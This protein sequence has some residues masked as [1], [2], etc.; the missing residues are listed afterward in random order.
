MT[1]AKTRSSVAHVLASLGPRFLP[2]AEAASDDL[3]LSRLL[4][5]SLFQISV[6]M[7]MVMLVGTLNRVMIVELQVPATLVSLMVALPLLVA[8]LRALIG[9]RSDNHRSQLGWRRVPYIWMGSLL[10]FGGFSI[11]PFAL[12]VLAGAGQSSQAPSWVGLLGAAGAFVLVGM[13]MHTVQTA[14]LALAT[15]LAPP[16]R[17]PQVVGLMYVMQLVGMIGS[18]LMLGHLLRDYSPGQLIRVVQAVAVMTLVLNVIALWKQEPR[19]RLRK[20]GTPV[21]HSFSQAWQLFCQ[22]PH[23]V[24]RL[25]AVGLG[26]MAFTMEDVL[27]EPY[28]G[29]ILGL[30]VSTTTLL[31]A[32][33]AFGGLIGFAWASRVLSR[34]ADAYRM[35][36]W[37]A[38]VG[39]PAFAAVIGSAPLDS[40]VLFALGIFLIGLGGGLFA[41]GTL[42]AAMQMAPPEHVGLAMGAWGAVQATAAGVGMATG[43]L[44]RDG[45]AWVSSSVVAY[46]SVY[47]VEIVLL[48]LTLWA[49]APLM[50][51]WRSLASAP[52][53]YP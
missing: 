25:L 50:R 40:P 34:G 33:L 44:V 41:H 12:L 30:S 48:V 9:Y 10:Q 43:G 38:W 7:A 52:V 5:L 27:L 47:F 4:R 45:V 17:Q 15:D 6:G 32:T 24:R 28:G 13:G 16:E 11:M 26:T 31:T 3:P 22:G 2:F 29:E 53:S 19:S 18:A 14:G 36:S 51:P 20:P 39:V 23:T 46:S 8:P 1:K 37:G 35:A 21:E 42:T 49:V